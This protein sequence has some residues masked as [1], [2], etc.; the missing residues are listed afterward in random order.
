M[1]LLYAIVAGLLLG[2]LTGGRLDGIATV[3]FRLWWLA[4]AGLAFQVVLFSGPIASRVGDLGPVLYVASSAAVFLA[5]LPN[6]SRPGFLLIAIGALLNLV[7]ILANGGFM[8][9]SG[10]AWMA[11][12]GA[13]DVPARDYTNSELIGTNTVL[14]ALGDIFVLPRP[15]PFA[16]VFSIGD[17]LIGV[18]A[19]W[20]L[21][22]TM[23]RIPLGDEQAPPAPG[24]VRTRSA[25][26]RGGSI[27]TVPE[28]R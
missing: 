15:M 16:N 17:V 1:L 20:F 9:S 21:I 12:N 11:L 10:E 24:A 5:L 28:P 26:P 2:R 22:R 3:R 6:R 4:L 8:P 27:R 19:A 13:P 18:G 14:P 23:H 25:G 7:A